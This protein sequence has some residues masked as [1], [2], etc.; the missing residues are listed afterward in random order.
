MAAAATVHQ[1]IPS[2]IPSKTSA[3]KNIENRS[4]LMRSE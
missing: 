4:P 3:T 1:M 2:S